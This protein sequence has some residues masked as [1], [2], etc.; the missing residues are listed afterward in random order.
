MSETII[1]TDKE[2]LIVL[3]NEV[4]A[5]LL[6]WKTSVRYWQMVD[7]KAKKNSQDKVDAQNAIASNQ[8]DV[9]KDTLWLK[10]IDEEIASL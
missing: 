7:K 2:L 1:K 6:K 9:K 10:A 4:N 3:R 8:T 5:R